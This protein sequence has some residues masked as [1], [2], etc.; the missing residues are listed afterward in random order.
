M[1]AVVCFRGCGCLKAIPDVEKVARE[2][3]LA[4]RNRVDSD[5][6]PHGDEMGR[7][8]ESRLARLAG[9]ILLPMLGQDGVN[10]GARAAL[11]LGAGDMHDVQAV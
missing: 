9:G 10:K 6:L 8:E 3:V 1:A 4:Y 7:D 2:E 5:A 11:A